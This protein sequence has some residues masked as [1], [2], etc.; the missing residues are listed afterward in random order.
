MIQSGRNPA[1]FVDCDIV[2]TIIYS[3]NYNR[4]LS[5]KKFVG[6]F[7]LWLCVEGF[8]FDVFD[9]LSINGNVVLY[10]QTAEP[11]VKKALPS[12]QKDF[13]NVLDLKLNYHTN[14]FEFY[15]RFHNGNGQGGDKFFSDYLFANV[16]TLADDNTEENYDLKLLEAYFSFSFLNGNLNIILG[17][18][19]PFLFI[20]QNEFA[21][22]ETTRFIGKPFVDNI[23]FDIEDR[24]SPILGFNYSYKNLEFS[25][26]VQS[27]EKHEVLFNGSR[28]VIE[29]TGHH[30]YDKQVSSG[31]QV[32]YKTDFKGLRGN[33]RFF[34]YNNTVSHFLCGADLDNPYEM[35]QLKTASGFGLSF[36]QFLTEGFGV[37]FRYGKSYKKLHPYEDFY[38]L[39]FSY[40]G[41]FADKDTILFGFSK[42][43]SSKHTDY[44]DE[45]H[46]EFQYKYEISENML[47][48]M[49]YQ[50]VQNLIG[51]PKVD[52]SVLTF[53]LTMAF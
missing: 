41:V 16:N 38:S 23:F 5:V 45:N 26:F 53:R 6:F 25:G 46:F 37:F 24:Y 19:E 40:S 17:K 11:T 39:G 22:D 29:E 49:D 20:D 1:F 21:N 3:E 14:F 15:T 32:N 31:F 51:F 35:P 2:L 43:N 4:G 50:Y 10:F 52:L 9:G 34:I 12:S 27:I 36:D 8:A 42:V 48:A 47:I 44:K 33:Y 28:W 18:T 30:D 13:G 7:M